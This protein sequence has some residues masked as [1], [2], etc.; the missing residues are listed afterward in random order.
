M[1]YTPE[2]GGISLTGS[3]YS[4]DRIEDLGPVDVRMD[5]LLRS[6]SAVERVSLGGRVVRLS[7]MIKGSTGTV[8]Q[9]NADALYAKL[10]TTT[11]QVLRLADDRYLDVYV[12]PGSV[13]VVTGAS[14]AVSE[15]SATFRS[16]SPYWR[17]SAE[18]TDSVTNTTS[19]PTDN[20]T[21]TGKAPSLPDFEIANTG[22][23]NYT[24][25]TVTISNGTSGEQFR[26][27]SLDLAAGDTLYIDASTGEV[28]LGAGSS[29][30][31]NAPKRVD[32]MFFELTNGVT[33]LTY[34]HTFGTAGDITFRCLHYERHHT[35]G[36]LSP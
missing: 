22:L 8:W 32:G 27:F 25:E 14:G 3:T 7:G 5:G 15:W 24:G 28:Y 13:E 6:G 18:T 19:A 12:D 4:V 35:Y 1:T 33:T 2:I 36:D 31:S 26:L 17:G 30:L 29:T 11:A 20:I 16:K 9:T 34:T 10:H 21:L 23:S